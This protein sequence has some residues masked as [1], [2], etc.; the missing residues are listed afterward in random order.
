MS[1]KGQRQDDRGVTPAPRSSA[2]PGAQGRY[3]MKTLVPLP[4]LALLAFTLAGCG[5]GNPSRPSVPLPVASHGGRV[6]PSADKKAYV[7]I[8]L[9][10][11]ASSKGRPVTQVVT[12]WLNAE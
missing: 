12:Y 11:P 7:E 1:R 10:S 5:D 8:E 4:A 9:K 6:F 2:H 3:P